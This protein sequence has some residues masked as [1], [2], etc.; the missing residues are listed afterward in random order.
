MVVRVRNQLVFATC[1]HRA[2]KIWGPKGLISWVILHH[3]L[4][5]W[6]KPLPY[7]PFLLNPPNSETC[8][9]FHNCFPSNIHFPSCSVFQPQSGAIAKDKVGRRQAVE[10]GFSGRELQK[11]FTLE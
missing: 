9:V 10:M 6:Q 3:H 11:P 5:L 7:A 4:Q 1:S 2:E 8:L